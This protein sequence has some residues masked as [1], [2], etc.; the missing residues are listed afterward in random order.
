MSGKKTPTIVFILIVIVAG[1]LWYRGRQAQKKTVAVPAKTANSSAQNAANSVDDSSSASSDQSAADQADANFEVQCQSGAWQKVA[2]VPGDA[3]TLDGK[4]RKVYPEDELPPELKAFPY[5]VQGKENAA[6]S[7]ADLSQ[8]DNFEGRDVEVQGVKSSDGKSVTVS[9]V[10]CAGDETDKTVIDA[11]NNLMNWLAA[12]INSV[13]PA[14]APYQKWT[15]DTAEFVDANDVY[16]EYYDAAEDDENANIPDNVDTS[17]KI[18]LETTAKPDGSYN[19][20]VL[21]YWEMGNEDYVL[22]TGVDKF[23]NATDTISYQY[24]PD[25]KSWTRI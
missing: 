23:E 2:D 20:K 6:L 16:V 9:E 24:D 3:V 25:A 7:G 11:R 13:A 4:L 12:N 18:L 15:V 14:K 10:R 8:L 21:A 19:A 5:Y 17:R 1:F 22:K